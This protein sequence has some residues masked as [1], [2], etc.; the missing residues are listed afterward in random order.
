MALVTG[1]SRGIG[2]G[3]V[4][5]FLGEGA[6]VAFNG[7]GAAT[8]EAAMAALPGG[9]TL[10]LIADL[11]ES[12]APRRLVQ[13]TVAR[14]GGLDI[15][16]NNAGVV[17]R[18]SLWEI[19]PGEWDHV[20]RVNLNA[21]FFAAREAALAMRERGGG[22]ILNMSSIAAQH[23]GIA[24]NPAY[25]SSKAALIGL[26]R[27]LARR[28]APDRIRVNC[29]APADIDT[30]VTA[31]WPQ[32]LRDTLNGMTPLGRFGAVEEV[33]GAAVYLCSDEASYVTGQTLAI[34]GGAYMG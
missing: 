28:F 32:A 13:E 22:A 29:L 34:N 15:L 5:A 14:L 17:S 18:A 33:T 3:I 21:S 2:L 1:G 4:R 23:G 25:A 8:V 31:G 16:V 19:E 7:T 24:G 20:H 11:S 9:E 26:T 27:S 6:R 30:D 10:P 12:T